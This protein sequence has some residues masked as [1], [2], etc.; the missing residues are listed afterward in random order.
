MNLTLKN[1]GRVGAEFFFR[2]GNTSS[3]RGKEAL[4]ARKISCFNKHGKHYF[5]LLPLTMGHIRG[6]KCS[7]VPGL[8][9]SYV[10]YTVSQTFWP[11]NA[12]PMDGPSQEMRDPQDILGMATL[13]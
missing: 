2:P 1:S 5:F 10:L 12:F 9:K 6:S 8:F 13:Y 7:Y 3:R 11:W 4:S